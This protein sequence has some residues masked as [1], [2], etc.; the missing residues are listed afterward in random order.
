[1]FKQTWTF[2]I[3]LKLH[4]ES[5]LLMKQGLI[6]PANICYCEYEWFFIPKYNGKCEN[7]AK[8]NNL[9]IIMIYVVFRCT[10]KI[11]SEHNGMDAEN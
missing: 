1:M 11:S 6:G 8:N 5:E 10:F 4:K 7:I 3:P 2:P 9:S